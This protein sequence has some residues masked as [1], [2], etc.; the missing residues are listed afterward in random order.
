MSQRQRAP[1]ALYASP[2][3]CS[4]AFTSCGTYSA[5][6]IVRCSAVATLRRRSVCPLILQTVTSGRAGWV[7]RGMALPLCWCTSLLSSR[8]SQASFCGQ[9][10][11]ETRSAVSEQCAACLTCARVMATASVLWRSAARGID[12]GV[13]AAH[14]QLHHVWDAASCTAGWLGACAASEALRCAWWQAREP[15]VRAAHRAAHGQAAAAVLRRA[16]ELGL[17]AS[18]CEAREKLTNHPPLE[19]ESKGCTAGCYRKTSNKSSQAC[20]RA[21]AAAAVLLLLAAALGPAAGNSEAGQ[22]P[23]APQRCYSAP[24]CAGQSS[25]EYTVSGG[26]NSTTFTFAVRTLACLPPRGVCGAQMHGSGLQ[27]WS[28]EASLQACPVDLRHGNARW[29][30]VAIPVTCERKSTCRAARGARRPGEHASA[31]RRLGRT[32]LRPRSSAGASGATRPGCGAWEPKSVLGESATDWALS[33]SRAQVEPHADGLQRFAV[34][35]RDALANG[36]AAGLAKPQNAQL[37]AG[38]GGD[39]ARGPQALP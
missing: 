33:G 39:G 36:S 32:L 11:W 2:S 22:A 10:Y 38:A 30:A 3:G 14:R 9:D 23:Q 29:C 15:D 26:P 13:G 37:S 7:T 4:L 16:E 31:L 1:C 24:V 8:T 27:L 25:F 20:A 12:T 18:S 28:V 34:R 6:S 35:V 5:Q 21:Q 19:R 17:A